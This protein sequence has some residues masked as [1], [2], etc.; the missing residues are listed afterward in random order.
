MWEVIVVII[1]IFL[2]YSIKISFSRPL[3][4]PLHSKVKKQIHGENDPDDV[5]L[6]KGSQGITFITPQGNIKKKCYFFDGWKTNTKFLKEIENEP[7]VPQ[8]IGYNKSDLSIIMEHCGELPTSNNLPKD[9]A[10]QLRELNDVL[11]R[12]NLFNADTK[13]I[14][15][16]TVK[17][18]H[19][20]L[21]DWG[22]VK[23]G[24]RPPDFSQILR[25]NIN[26]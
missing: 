21:V 20:Y 19:L 23:Y 12:H 16:Y 26:S 10:F 5:F 22:T 2:M 4:S 15:N 11:K 3:S 18:N 1:I 14:K 24:Y 25:L 17:N 9:F 13:P 6:A 7:H 8:L